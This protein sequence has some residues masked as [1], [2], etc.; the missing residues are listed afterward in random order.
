MTEQLHISRGLQWL[1]LLSAV[2][3]G[4]ALLCQARKLPESLFLCLS[5]YEI[6]KVLASEIFQMAGSN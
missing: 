3:Q 2:P 4:E 5:C 1:A 6:R